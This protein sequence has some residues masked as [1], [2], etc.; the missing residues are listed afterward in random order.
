MPPRPETEPPRWLNRLRERVASLETAYDWLQEL[1]RLR[2]WAERY[3]PDLLDPNQ[4][5]IAVVTP[6]GDVGQV[7]GP[8]DWFLANL[9]A[10]DGVLR[11]QFDRWLAE[12]RRDVP[13]PVRR[14]GPAAQADVFG[15][16]QFRNWRDLRIVEYGALLIWRERL[17]TAKRRRM[18]LTLIG[19]W[20]GRYGSNDRKRTKDALK[21]ALARLPALAAQAGADRNVRET[22]TS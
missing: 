2:K 12:K 20:T 3:K 15:V 18:T 21:G 4:A 14:R 9:S 5:A 16:D 13:S 22:D 7:G 19:E 17:P 11:E 8:F 6:S 1:I 10:P